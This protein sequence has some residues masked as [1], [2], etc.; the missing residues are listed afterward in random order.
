MG[1][2]KSLIDTEYKELKKFRNFL[3]LKAKKNCPIL[4]GTWHIYT[5]FFWKIISI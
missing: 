1:L 5:L 4:R 2:L 3:L